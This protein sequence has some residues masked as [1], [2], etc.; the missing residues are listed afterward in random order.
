MQ[1]AE[2]SNVVQIREFAH[3]RGHV[4]D[5]DRQAV[6]LAI[7]QRSGMVPRPRAPYPGGIDDL[8]V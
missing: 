2:K 4:A 8:P 1:Q 7:P 6:V 3:L 5:L